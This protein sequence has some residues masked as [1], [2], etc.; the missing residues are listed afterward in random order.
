MYD[1]FQVKLDPSSG[2]SPQDVQC[3]VHASLYSSLGDKR[4]RTAEA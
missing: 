2:L 1:V 4:R 3:N